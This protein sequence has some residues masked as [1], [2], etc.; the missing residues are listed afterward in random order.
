VRKLQ[1]AHALMVKQHVEHLEVI[2]GIETEN[3]YTVYADNGGN[4]PLFECEE[5]SGFM[6]RWFLGSSRPFTLRIMSASDRRPFLTVQRPWRFYYHS[7]SVTDADSRV[8]G[9]VTRKLSLCTRQ[10][11]VTDSAGHEAF[12]VSGPLFNPWT[13]NITQGGAQVGEISKK[14]SGV[15]QEMFTDADNFGVTFHREMPLEVKSLVLAT[16]FLIDFMYFEDNAPADEGM[17]N[18]RRRA[19]GGGLASGRW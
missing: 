3:R 5:S 11:V 4:V 6:Q 9:T 13:F 16:V 18:M 12:R 10:Y 8:I 17:G 1:G 14:F 7:I 19:A 15:M 2:S